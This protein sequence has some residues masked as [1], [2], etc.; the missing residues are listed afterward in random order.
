MKNEDFIDKYRDRIFYDEDANKNPLALYGITCHSGWMPLIEKCARDL[1]YIDKENRVRFLQIKEKFGTLRFYISIKDYNRD[2]DLDFYNKCLSI[3]RDAEIE[4]QHTCE[5]CSNP[6]RD[7]KVR[8]F[9]HTLCD[10]CFI[11]LIR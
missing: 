2:N 5:Y 6:G 8:N 9:I 1:V 10:S 3:I 7:H 4:S 11:D